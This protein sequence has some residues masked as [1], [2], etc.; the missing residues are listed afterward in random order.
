[1]YQVQNMPVMVKLHELGRV[2]D[3]YN[4]LNTLNFKPGNNLYIDITKVSAITP[5]YP[6]GSVIFSVSDDSFT[7]WESP[8][9]VMEI[10][11][12]AVAA[13]LGRDWNTWSKPLV[14]KEDNEL[15]YPWN[16]EGLE[17]E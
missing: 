12:Q 14:N 13:E 2:M 16:E 8:E 7:T 15:E 1:M 5:H 3:S 11:K 10:M 6:V 17:D 9:E 4:P